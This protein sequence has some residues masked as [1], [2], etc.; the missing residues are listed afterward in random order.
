MLRVRIELARDGSAMALAATGHARGKVG[1]N[2]A[3]AA[4]TLLVRTAAKWLSGRADIRINGSAP[5]EGALSFSAVLAPVG[6]IG[7]ETACIDGTRGVE[8]RGGEKNNGV[9][10]Y[11]DAN[12]RDGVNKRDGVSNGDV[13]SDRN[14]AGKA[15]AATVLEDLVGFLTVG[16]RDLE[17]EFPRDV[18]VEVVIASDEVAGNG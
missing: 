15:R 3:C 14:D 17:R 4:G 18:A 10:Q 16:F 13:G 2:I 8:A 11:R 9:K 12:E 1:E 6:A 5:H 7:S